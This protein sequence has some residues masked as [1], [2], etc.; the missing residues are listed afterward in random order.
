MAIK[1]MNEFILFLL[2][3]ILLY[4]YLG[5]REGQTSGMLKG[6]T[7]QK[8]CKQSQ[9]VKGVAVTADGKNPWDSSKS[10]DWNIANQKRIC[11]ERGKCFKVWGMGL[12]KE[13]RNRP[14]GPWCYEPEA[15]EVIKTSSPPPPPPPPS[16]SSKK[17]APK[18]EPS[19][20]VRSLTE[21]TQDG[22]NSNIRFKDTTESIISQKY[23]IEADECKKNCYNK[24]ICKSADFIEEGGRCI[25]YKTN[26]VESKDD[27][28]NADGISHW[29]K[30]VPKV[31]QDTNY[32]NVCEGGKEYWWFPRHD[33]KFVGKLGDDE[34][35]KKVC[36]NDE[37]CDMWLM[38][39]TGSCYNG[40]IRDKNL[41]VSCARPGWGKLYGQVK[42]NKELSIFNE[43]GGQT[44]K[45]SGLEA[46]EAQRLCSKYNL[47]QKKPYDEI[48]AL[49]R[50]C[51]PGGCNLSWKSNGPW[52]DECLIPDKSR[53]TCCA[54]RVE[55]PPPRPPPPPP[56]P[57]EIDQYSLLP[58]PEAQPTKAI[59][60]F[61]KISSH[62]ASLRP[63]FKRGEEDVPVEMKVNV[64][65]IPLFDGIE[66]A[67]IKTEASKEGFFGGSSD[68]NNAYVLREGLMVEKPPGP[69]EIYLDKINSYLI[70]RDFPLTEETET[71]VKINLNQNN[72]KSR[73]ELKKDIVQK[74][75]KKAAN[76][77]ASNKKKKRK[78]MQEYH[79]KNPTKIIERTEGF[80]GQ[81]R[82][83]GSRDG[84]GLVQ[85]VRRG[86][87]VD[88]SNFYD[89]TYKMA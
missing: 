75:A 28:Q 60:I 40:K 36:D 37:K 50:R 59:G 1:Y 48:K 41:R 6:L 51:E 39:E 25:L 64:D 81:C 83:M 79:R 17:A 24:N 78:A 54:K 45:F 61:N 49:N 85:C 34:A 53:W 52:K 23:G 71:E 55:P 70:K 30:P 47:Q 35:C 42:S 72:K 84:V 69:A 65:T 46:D 38:S 22:W 12:D 44:M 74:L 19:T 77:L 2:L 7:T 15:T 56:P 76:I 58:P 26:C 63:D 29:M 16:T 80:K 66:D 87:P 86:P 27:C 18:P 68:L 21:T 62:L 89:E 20:K 4:Y 3:G 9:P 67:K 10:K 82:G 13:G 33:K 8:K 43:R 88:F 57:V 32:L 11:E 5:I 73:N 14:A 31:I